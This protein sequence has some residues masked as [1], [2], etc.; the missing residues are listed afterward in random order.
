MKHDWRLL[1][2]PVTV[3]FVYYALLSLAAGQN[4]G[5]EEAFFSVLAFAL[6]LDAAAY[7]CYCF[8]LSPEGD[9]IRRLWFVFLTLYIL[10]TGPTLLGLLRKMF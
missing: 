3:T 7:G 8:L 1:K 5:G 10:L 2:W 4:A 9:D 6:A